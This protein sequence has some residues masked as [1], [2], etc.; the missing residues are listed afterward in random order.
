MRTAIVLSAL[1]P[2]ALSGVVPTT[3]EAS[4]TVSRDKR[5]D[6]ALQSF[7][8]KILQA[9]V[10][11]GVAILNQ[12]KYQSAKQPAQWKTC[13]SRNIIV[14]REW[15]A[16][17]KAE[18]KEYIKAVQCLGK[19]PPKFPKSVCPGCQNRYDDFVATH[20]RQ[21]FSIHNTGNFLPWHRYFT[22]AYEK[23]LRDE[24]DYKGYQPYYNWPKWSD[25]PTK[26]P[27][28]DGSETSLGGNGE[29]GCTNQT[30]Y[31]IPT[32]VDPLIN[33]P[34]GS[35]GGCIASGPMKGWPVN[36]GPVFT[37]L[38]CTPNNPIFDYADPTTA[39]QVGLGYNP[40]C[41][42]RDISAWTS[43]QWT[44]D[45]MVTK[46]LNSKDMKTFWYDMQGGEVA[47]SNNFMGVHTAGH[48]TVGGDPGSDF[49][50]SPGD[51][52][53]YAH[54]AQIDRVWWT[55]QNLSP[56]ERTKAIYGTTV[57]ADPTA[58]NSTLSDKM[59]LEYA[60]A[61]NITVGDAMSTMAGPFCYTYI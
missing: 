37:D 7:G 24:C 3:E 12:Q 38:T 56:A 21:T 59:T 32:N 19:L 47:F 6:A 54:H 41:L 61:G 55:W 49:L 15:S 31:G 33:I 26:S 28:L 34:H 25:D 1:L 16:F 9:D 8:G 18:K 13:N 11:A 45:N 57:L 4:P 50:N 20:I 60:F 51:P 35:G 23:T 14:R 29:L 30:S 2:A 48:F 58:P 17:S 53:F 46:L 36:L 40:R 10:L 5:Q 39:G 42:K 44:N 22:Y 43:R 27:L 52:Y